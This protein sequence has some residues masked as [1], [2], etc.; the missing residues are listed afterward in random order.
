MTTPDPNNPSP[1][2]SADPGTWRFADVEFDV[3]ALELRVQGEAVSLQRKPLEL[4]RT[5]LT[6]AGEVVTKEELLEAVWPGRIVTDATLTKAMAKLRLAIGDDDQDIIRTVHGYGYRLMA[7]AER[8]ADGRRRPSPLALESGMAVPQR[9]NFVLQ[10]RL[11]S[12]GA[13][14]VWLAAHQK[15]REA[16][17][18]KF[19]LDEEQLRSLRREVTI[20]RLL[21]DALGDHPGFV[22]IH[23]WNFEEPPFFIEFEHIAGGSLADAHAE[24]VQWP[25]PERLELVARLADTLADAHGLGVL[26]KDLKPANVLLTHDVDGT[27]RPRLCDF[28]TGI[29]LAP[30][31]LDQFGITRMGLT[32]T[33]DDD[34]TSSGT[35]LYIA[36]EVVAGQAPTARAD[37]FA[38]GVL[39][40]QI[41]VGDLQRPLAAGWEEDVDDALLREDIAAAAHGTWQRR[42][43]DARELAERLRG[44][45]ARRM[46]RAEAERLEREAAEARTALAR[47]RARRPWIAGSVL[48]LLIGMG[49]S[50]WQWQEARLA[51]AAV[52]QEAA[53]SAAVNA[54]LTE[55]LLAAANP[56]DASGYDVSIKE[57]LERTV[58][59]LDADSGL[60]PAVESA[61]RRSIGMSFLK[62]GEDRSAEVQ[63]RLAHSLA[64]DSFGEHV[65][66]TRQIAALLAEAL[67]YQGRT[68]E[69]RAL[70]AP[71]AAPEGS[72]E[73]LEHQLLA[74]QALRFARELP[75]AIELYEGVQ[76]DLA[77]L[78]DPPADLQE[79]A[80][81]GLLTALHD[82]GRLAGALPLIEDHL[83]LLRERHGEDS[84][85]F[86]VAQSFL[87]QHY[88]DTGNFEAA[89]S[90][91]LR[92]REG[93]TP[94]LG[95]GHP[96]V[97]SVL[98]QLGSLYIIYQRLEL[99]AKFSELAFEARREQYGEEHAHTLGSLNNLAM[100]LRGLERFEEALA[101]QRLA[102]DVARRLHGDESALVLMLQFHR[103]MTLMESGQLTEARPLLLEV[104]ERASDIFDPIWQGN[105][106]YG[107]GRLHQAEGEG[108]EAAPWLERALEHYTAQGLADSPQADHIRA[109]LANLR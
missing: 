22:H 12:G 63:L 83:D 60:E 64:L 89:E 72:L 18:F 55:D 99:A 38:L 40:Y 56:Y 49:F 1:G 102:E 5:L 44:L 67:A 80:G 25:L 108:E 93:L 85:D 3:A 91:Y 14:E 57:L 106:A 79:R 82:G 30:D 81:D 94:R 73:H 11:G 52:E 84:M 53:R 75:A 34:E 100:A 35:P 19:S 6:H 86:L 27:A 31:R 101:K 39:L 92:M 69:V 54:F 74:A 29:L 41:A 77:N 8:V 62:F 104:A 68:D 15:T 87:A 98:H 95:A 78:P 26:H 109:T 48:V 50:T 42:L 59:A 24:I 10:R 97:A 36:P 58:A 33:A 37:V 107:V 103:G 76:H 65:D 43:G 46:A 28:G 4:L 9:P 61:V 23:D 21:H 45:E 32:R 66:E 20:Y 2:A 7:P 13:G 47:T 70:L 88:R 17:V 90:A 71:L 96:V 51:R 105:A 16:R